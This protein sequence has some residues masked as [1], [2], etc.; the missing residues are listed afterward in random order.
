MY[1]VVV[2]NTY[3]A[4][5]WA[6]GSLWLVFLWPF[7]CSD[8]VVNCTLQLNMQYYYSQA[9]FWTY[10][11]LFYSISRRCILMY[12]VLRRE[13]FFLSVVCLIFFLLRQYFQLEWFLNSSKYLEKWKLL[14][15]IIYK[16]HCWNWIQERNSMP[17]ILYSA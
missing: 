14:K 2:T 6:H 1:V 15:D 5:A 11:G 8:K 12:M 10:F 4:K 7:S 3:G 17:L 13:G 9:I 16:A